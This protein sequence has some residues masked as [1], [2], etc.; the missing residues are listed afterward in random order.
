M[1]MG[2]DRLSDDQIDLVRR[3]IEDGARAEQADTG[4]AAVAAADVV[5][6]SETVTTILNVKCLLCHGRRNQEGGLDLQTRASLLQGGVSGPAIVPGKPDESLLIRRIES[7]DMP[8]R[9]DQARLSVRAVT[10]SELER[11]RAWIS[12]GAPYDER[13]PIPVV[14]AKDPL[15]S[16][17]DRDFWSFRT[18]ARP[19]VPDGPSIR[20]GFA[21]PSTPSCWRSWNKRA[22][23]SH[24]TLH[25]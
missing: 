24:P 13:K 3:W 17:A 8:P 2:A 23:P 9:K 15:V 11:L 12:A 14:A 16:N 10:S 1:P 22:A 19:R 18:P 5:A 4:T 21:L 20:T 7:Q 25:P 6:G